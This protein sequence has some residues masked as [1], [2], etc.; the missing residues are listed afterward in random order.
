MGLVSGKKALVLGIANERSLA[1]AIARYLVA[2]G[3]ELA[4]TYQGEVFADRVAK[5]KDSL[6]D[7]L[8][9]SC[10]VSSDADI[11]RTFAEVGEAMGSID[12]LLHAI[13]YAEKEDL[14]GPYYTVSRAGFLKALE[15]GAYSFTAV[16]RA[17]VPFMEARGGS[18]LTL[19]YFG[20]EK[21]IP[22]YNVMGVTKAALEASVRYLSHDLG[23][24]NIRVNALSAGPIK[25]LS[26]KGVGDFSSMLGHAR[27]KACLQR[28][29]TAEDIGAA[30][31]FLLSDSSSGITG[32]TL[33]VDCGYNVVGM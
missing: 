20:A 18:M 22:H 2:E 32:E 29:V 28:N 31:L 21:V 14:V 33:H 11:E 26:A 7:P 30:G 24:K 3:A 5:L 10:D 13:A 9:V 12:M 1:Y 4:V 27:E 16:A 8:L 25:T 15:I 19:T 17:A 23:P 6:G